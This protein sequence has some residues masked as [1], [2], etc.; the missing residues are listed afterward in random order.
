MGIADMKG[1]T[2]DDIFQ[3]NNAKELSIHYQKSDGSTF[4]D[5][6]YGSTSS[7]CRSSR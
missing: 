4:D 2:L 1:D 7:A 6:S 3:L 5:Y